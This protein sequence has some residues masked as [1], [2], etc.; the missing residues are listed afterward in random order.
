LNT[1]TAIKLINNMV[2]KKGWKFEASSHCHRYENT[3]SVKVTYPAVDSGRPNAEIGYS[4]HEILG[5]AYAYFPVMLD[6]CD[7]VERLYACIIKMVMEIEM[8]EAREFLRSG[9]TYWAPFH[10][11]NTDGMERA[12]RYGLGTVDKD[13][14]FGLT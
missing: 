14:A 10:P 9:D 12:E 6:R 3:I 7:S 5:G 8:H 13:L 2:Y 1:D 4:G 11:H